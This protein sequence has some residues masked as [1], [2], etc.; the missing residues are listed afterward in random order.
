MDKTTITAVR[1]AIKG[2]ALT[3]A[4]K[5]KLDEIEA[6]YEEASAIKSKAEDLQKDNEKLQIK[7]MAEKG[8]RESAESVIEDLKEMSNENDKKLKKYDELVSKVDELKSENENLQSLKVEQETKIRN[9]YQALID[10]HK[11][12]E[13]FEKWKDEFV[14]PSEEKKLEDMSID[15]IKASKERFDKLIERGVFGAVD[16]RIAGE[17]TQ[18]IQKL[19]DLEEQNKVRKTMGLPPLKK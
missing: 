1:E 9:E 8:R 10:K 12:A 14:L 3:D 11:D 7:F 15:E 2:D 13:A 18:D 5:A 17:Q 16:T 6:F 19:N 4:V